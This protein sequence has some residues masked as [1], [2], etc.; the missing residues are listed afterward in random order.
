[1]FV[2][3][4]QF[5][6]E[7]AKAFLNFHAATI[8]SLLG[9]RRVQIIQFDLAFLEAGILH[10]DGLGEAVLVV[11]A[12]MVKRIKKPKAGGLRSPRVGVY[13]VVVIRAG[14]EANASDSQ[15]NRNDFDD[16]V[17]LSFQR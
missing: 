10:Q 14:G 12:A 15:K 16:R 13:S 4:F 7:D 5:K 6:G 3:D 9:R 11:A 1:M 2:G 8:A 17:F